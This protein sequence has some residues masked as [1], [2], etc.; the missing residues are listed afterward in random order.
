MSE[1]ATYFP[2]PKTFIPA[3]TL[4]DTLPRRATGV[5]AAFSS[6]RIRPERVGSWDMDKFPHPA[7]LFQNTGN[8]ETRTHFQG[9]QRLPNRPLMVVSGGDKKN[10]VSHLFLV[11]CRPRSAWGP[12]GSNLW[13]NPKKPPNHD[14]LRR[15]IGLDRDRWH[16]GGT[17]VLG[18]VIAVP[19][20]GMAPSQ[21]VF[22]D[23]STPTAPRWA[24]ASTTITCA[25]AGTGAVALT[26]TPS[27]HFLCAAWRDER[28]NPP[29]PAGQLDF[30]I[31]KNPV[32][33]AAPRTPFEPEW[34]P[35]GTWVYARPS[36]PDMPE[37][38]HYQG[39][40]FAWERDTSALF[41]LATR[42]TNPFAPNTPGEDMVD[43]FQVT[44][45]AGMAL[46]G[47]GAPLPASTVPTPVY[48]NSRRLKGADEFCSFAAGGGAFV[49]DSGALVL[50]GAFHFRGD[51]LFR[52]S[53]YWGD[54]SAG[55]TWW[56]DLFERSDF[57][58]HRLSILDP[59][60]A[61]VPEYRERFA[62]GDKFDVSVV[63]ARFLLPAGTTYRLFRQP[64]CPAN[65]PAA[66]VLDLAGTGQ[67]VEIPRLEAVQPA[68][69]RAV[70][71]SSIA[72]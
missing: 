18:D 36:H 49:S 27:G 68:F 34:Q 30:F 11:E 20:E 39:I 45:P 41:L 60:E 59:A 47:T 3:G 6:F 23:L 67:V 22:L 29:E 69:G 66:E 10:K 58:G 52:M 24:A 63:S 43:L 16:A 70:R 38:P 62:Q 35:L 17:S 4:L 44:P 25:T 14:R 61:R 71:S 37:K 56:I 8:G 54:S 1:D 7:Y 33:A 42:N 28:Q 12:L 72:P 26:R 5:V 48:V 32:P 46:T 9:I 40:S 57:E 53:E 51:G 55:A 65:A 19:L 2:E 31:S 50:Y 15:V 21:I 64:G 13:T